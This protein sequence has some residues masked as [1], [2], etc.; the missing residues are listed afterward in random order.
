MSGRKQGTELAEKIF[1]ICTRGLLSQEVVR[2][3]PGLSRGED[4]MCPSCRRRL[5]ALRA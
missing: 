4:E 5:V 3:D 1:V 2:R